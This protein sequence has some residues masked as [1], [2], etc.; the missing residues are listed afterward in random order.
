MSY[1]LYVWHH[2]QSDS[3]VLPF[4]QP[5]VAK[6]PALFPTKPHRLSGGRGGIWKVY[7]VSGPNTDGRLLRRMGWEAKSQ[8]HTVG[9]SF[10]GTICRANSV[11]FTWRWRFKIR[12]LHLSWIYPDTFPPA[13]EAQSEPTT[14]R[15]PRTPQSVQTIASRGATSQGTVQGGK[16]WYPLGEA[17]WGDGQ[18]LFREVLIYLSF[19]WTF[20][21]CSEE[22][23]LFLVSQWFESWFSLVLYYAPGDAPS[24]PYRP[25][26]RHGKLSGF[27][28]KMGRDWRH[29]EFVCW[30]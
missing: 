8:K 30:M 7:Q 20:R 16:N 2:V 14:P 24:G 29:D 28:G 13:A 27:S 6:L 3:G 19:P 9:I 10:L 18:R 26:A 25:R 22:I 21:T 15:T 5:E 11:H 23:Q 4:L 1:R 12:L 17:E